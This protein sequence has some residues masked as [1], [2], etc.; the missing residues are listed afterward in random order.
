[1]LV[2]LFEFLLRKKNPKGAQKKGTT[3]V[4]VAGLY[5]K[6][7]GRKEGELYTF[8]CALFFASVFIR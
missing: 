6:C 4:F 3:K 7:R 8:L 2:T 1:M 5:M